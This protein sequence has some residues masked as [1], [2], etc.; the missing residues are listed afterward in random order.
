MPRMTRAPPP[1][2]PSPYSEPRPVEPLSYGSR[3]DDWVPPALRV[4][5]WVAIAA[6]GA[7]VL[8]GIVDLG[9]MLLAGGGSL[10]FFNT[11]GR[12]GWWWGAYR[13]INWIIGGV[14]LAGGFMCLARAPAARMTLLVWAFASLASGAFYVVMSTLYYIDLSNR[15]TGFDTTTIVSNT[16]TGVA[17][18]AASGAFPVIVILF[19][20]SAAVRQFFQ[21]R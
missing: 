2:P 7:H 20:L 14:A 19:M 3:I 12:Y 8:S 6:G 4:I 17:W 21:Y 13:I 15:G 10:R 9:T 1:L 18:M 16:F 11:F 5:G